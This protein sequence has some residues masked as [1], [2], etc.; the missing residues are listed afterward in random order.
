VI[1]NNRMYP[2]TLA[3]GVVFLLQ[4]LLNANP[5]LTAFFL[6]FGTFAVILSLWPRLIVTADGVTVVNARARTLAWGDIDAVEARSRRGTVNLVF[7]TDGEDIRAFA[8]R[9]SAWGY[10][11]SQEAVERVAAQLSDERRRRTGQVEAASM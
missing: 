5:K 4:G 9:G 10:L 6:V 1:R 2:V 8:M 3:I 11:N 7:R